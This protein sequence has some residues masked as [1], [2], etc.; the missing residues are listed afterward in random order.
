MA[1]SQLPQFNSQ[2]LLEQILEAGKKLAKESKKLAEEGKK[3]AADGKLNPA[4]L[5]K[6]GKKIAARGEDAL[7]DKLGIED[8][9]ASREALRKGVGTGAAA[10]ALALLLTSRSARKMAT[11]GGLAG[12]GA[13]AYRAHQSGQ[14]PESIDDVIGLI[15]GP[16]GDARAEIL[17][18]AMVAAA[19]ADGKLSAAEMAMIK[20][21]N[22]DSVDALEAALAQT[23]DAK[24][25]AALAKT[26]QQ[27]AEIYAVSCRV[28][29]GL[30]AK[31]RDYLDQLAMA[32]RLDPVVAAKLETDVR[33][34]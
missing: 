14:M 30:N 2:E 13:L 22:P 10:G 5:T 32:L 12:L 19:K 27:G 33:T 4:E 11:L 1:I 23:P 17:L 29:N 15:K 21:H 9:V 16:S 3:L 24:S 25:I 18:Q 26:D 34:G 28:A 31:E 8:T 20:A 6:R 7:I